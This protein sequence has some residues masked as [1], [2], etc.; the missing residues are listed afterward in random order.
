MNNMKILLTGHH[1]YIGSVMGAV[2]KNDGHQVVG[3]DSNFFEKCTL[4]NTSDGFE[5]LR[6]DIRDVQTSD[7]AGF[8]TVIHLAN[9]SN[10]PLGSLNPGL[11]YE[12]NHRASVR[13]ARIAKESGVQRF[14]FASSCSMYGA[15]S[16]DEILTEETPLRPLTPYAISKVRTEEDLDK[17]A[18]ADFSPVNLRNATAY[19]VSPRLRADIVLNNLVCWA[20]TTQ[21][22]RIMSDG[23]PWRPLVHIRD[24][25]NAT[26]AILTAPREKIHNQAFNIGKNDENYQVR[27]LAEIVKETIPG[28][29]VEYAPQS[30]ADPRNYRVNFN[31]LARVFPELRLEWNARL[32]AQELYQA[33]MKNGLSME[34]FQGRRYVRLKQLEY[35]IH[36]QEINQDLRWVK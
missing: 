30:A 22:I 19:G 34:D 27:D 23:T 29:E 4:E 33:F 17:L 12:I 28:C 20:F 26:L 13:L 6:K 31:K 21:K 32:G 24:I 25:T 8:D 3:L 18:D 36:S 35:L 15:A 11:T 2:L 10:D 1:G 5:S 7:M 14:I 16:N 9:L